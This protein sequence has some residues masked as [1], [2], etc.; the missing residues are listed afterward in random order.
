MLTS[1]SLSR[2]RW[3]QLSAGTL[4]S[5]GLW[6]GR[7]LWGDSGRGGEFRF[8][9]LN[10]THFHTPKC[11][12]WF[13]RVRTSVLSHD[14]KP[15][16]CLVVGDLAEEG[17]R[18]ELGG[19]REFLR[20]LGMEVHVAIGNHD[21]GSDS[22]RS[23]WDQL[24]PNSLNFSFNHRGWQFIGL[25][26]TQGREWQGTRIQPAAL[27]WLDDHL[28]KLRPGAPS[29]LFTHF[30]LGPDVRFRPLNA[31][32]VLTRFKPFNLVGVFDGHFHGFTERILGNGTVLT[33]NRCCAISRD[34]HD[35]SKEKGYFLC[36]ASN[37]QISRRFI[38]VAEL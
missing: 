16:L 19:M 37:G 11:P 35:G 21:Y 34:N 31:D 12:A 2:R 14:P 28:P 22:D 15:E 18:T 38:Q 13:Q 32:D 27:S 10:D 26:S 23:A 1:S 8:V 6:P 3:M 4:L 36:T 25:D 20:S 5:V 9:V 29:V 17:T 33:T 30:P 24:F 7:A